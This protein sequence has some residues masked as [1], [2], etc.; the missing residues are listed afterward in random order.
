VAAIW[1]EVLRLPAAG[2]E[3]D[4]FAAGGHS[5]LATRVIS[6]LRRAFGVDLPLHELFAGPTIA[7]LAL[8]VERLRGAGT[9]AETMPRTAGVIAVSRRERRLPPLPEGSG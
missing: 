4:F 1:C 7:E 2:V 6:R 5:L 8:A 9:T 3:D